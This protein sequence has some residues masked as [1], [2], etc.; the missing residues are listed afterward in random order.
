MIALALLAAVGLWLAGSHWPIGWALL[1]A[2][3]LLAIPLVLAGDPASV[4]LPVACALVALRNLHLGRRGGVLP[5]VWG[6][7]RR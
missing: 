3:Q 4:L 1:A 6:A 2:A 5:R 7:R